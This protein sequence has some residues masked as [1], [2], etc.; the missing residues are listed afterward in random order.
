MLK[1]LMKH[2]WKSV[3]KLPAFLNL[4]LA[5]IT[6]MAM[7]SFHSKIWETDNVVLNLLLGCTFLL[8]M[9]FLCL[10]CFVTILYLAVRF[11]RNLFTDEGYL[12]H[13]LPVTGRQLVVSK[14]LVSTA[15]Y[16]IT[17]VVLI[18]AGAGLV[19][20]LLTAVNPDFTL[21]ELLRSFVQ[22]V[23]PEIEAALGA[24]FSVLFTYGVIN[25][26]ISCLYANLFIY[27]C[28]ALGQQFT[29]H[30]IAGAVVNYIAIASVLS[31]INTL[32]RE[33][34]LKSVYPKGAAF[35]FASSNVFITSYAK[36]WS[37]FLIGERLLLAAVFYFIAEYLITK[38]LN[39]D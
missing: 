30:K 31:I 23:I 14:L 33:L 37:W 28:I 32:V 21:P 35:T 7:I 15:W 6:V 2:E 36:G 38:K 18:L 22:D 39:L 17:I 11:Y 1:K 9:L 16:L 24:P 29:K 10:S 26:I 3:W 12:M 27:V 13:T 5:G 20:G 34:L 4:V 19:F 8:Y 25:T